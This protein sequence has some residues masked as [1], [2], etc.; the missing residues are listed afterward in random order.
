MRPDVTIRK[1]KSVEVK[2]GELAKALEA[3][4]LTATVDMGE[5]GSVSALVLQTANGGQLR[6]FGSYGFELQRP[7]E[8][9]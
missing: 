6:I 8:V 5:H 1:W 4:G 7:V 3:L 2:D 9:L